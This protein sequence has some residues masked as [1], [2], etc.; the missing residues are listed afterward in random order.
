L[1]FNGFIDYAGAVTIGETAFDSKMLQER[2]CR[3]KWNKF[4][5]EEYLQKAFQL[6]NVI[7]NVCIP[8]RNEAAV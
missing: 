3:D 2:T 1:T 4:M 5:N 8:S 6:Q 7:Y